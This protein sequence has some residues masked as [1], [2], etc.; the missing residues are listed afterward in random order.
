MKKITM[1]MLAAASVMLAACNIN[2]PVAPATGEKTFTATIADTKTQL[3]ADGD[4]HHVNWV[5]GDKVAITN[6]EVT[7]IYKAVD[8]NGSTATFVLESGEEP[9]GRLT[10]FYPATLTSNRLPVKQTYV[11]GNI[12]GSPMVGTVDGTTIT[13]SNM[14]GILKL[15]VTGSTTPKAV[16]LKNISISADQGISGAFT[17]DGDAK[18]AIVSGTTGIAMDLDNV[19]L[20]E[21]ATPLYFVVP[22]GT[23]TGL[24]I[25][26]MTSDG[27]SQTLKAKGGSSIVVE[28]SKITEGAVTFNDFVAPVSG[29]AVLP[30]GRDF[31]T[32]IKQLINP[33]AEYNSPDESIHRIIFRVNDRS[34]DGERI[35]DLESEVPIYAKFDSVS[36]VVTINTAAG[37]IWTGPEASYMFCYLFAL[38]GIDNLGVLNTSQAETMFSMFNTY[39]GDSTL[40]VRMNE[41]IKTNSLLPELDLS[42]FNTSNVKDFT[43]M[44]NYCL[45]LTHIDV[46]S[47]DTSSGE[48]F[49]FMFSNCQNL[50]SLDVTNFDTSS[51]LTFRYM[52]NK[53]YALTSLDVSNFNTS[54][55]TNM[56]YMF[57]GCEGL[58]SLDV[59]KFDTSNV[60]NMSYMF[61]D[62]CNL[63]S[64]DVSTFDVSAVD[65]LLYTFAYTEKLPSLDLSNWDTYMVGTF[66][67]IFRHMDNCTSFKLDGFFTTENAFSLSYMFAQCRIL[68]EFSIPLETSGCKYFSY[69]FY[70]CYGLEKIDLSS[71]NAG[72]VTSSGNMGHMFEFMPNLKELILG[73]DFNLLHLTS[74]TPTNF[75]CASGQTIDDNR[76]CSVSNELTIRCSQATANWIARTNLR[77]I[78]SGWKEADPVPVAFYDIDTNAPISVEWAAN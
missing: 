43:N 27:E 30:P 44:F 15:N 67:N 5:L 10:A 26:A 74:N 69:M 37:E 23:Y 58:T 21:T 36:G 33:T 45:G 55:A 68:P 14:C 50:K 77:W 52:F 24:S 65:S 13:F 63:T 1:A 11:P 6:G 64:L 39:T 12:E 57:N 38:E 20:S 35:D 16:S 25:T 28:R 4:V 72:S 22:A 70:G 32:Y 59:S 18:T 56:S 7:G 76:T 17:F 66:S 53:C 78:N 9:E 2:E 40:I 54:N 73:E 31:I 61:Y 3:V 62:C 48:N 75:F 42:S 46:S 34:D 60:T 41:R 47:F 51:A 49:T 71:F 29:K 8:V 19:N